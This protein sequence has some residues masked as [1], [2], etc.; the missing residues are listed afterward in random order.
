MQT[1]LDLSTISNKNFIERDKDDE[2][3]IEIVEKRVDRS[4]QNPFH[5]IMIDSNLEHAVKLPK[6][7]NFR[8]LT[9]AN[10]R[11]NED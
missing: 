8:S 5:S 2:T 1:S 11:K 7:E 9:P 4:N 6:L 3:G 10:S